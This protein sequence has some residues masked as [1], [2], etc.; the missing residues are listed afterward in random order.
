MY[1]GSSR[2]QASKRL[3]LVQS[4]GLLFTA[5]IISTLSRAVSVDYGTNDITN[6]NR[7]FCCVAPSLLAIFEA[8]VKLAQEKFAV[9]SWKRTASQLIFI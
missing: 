6:Q 2:K 8:F 4:R 5:I 7:I 9:S 1:D 3:L